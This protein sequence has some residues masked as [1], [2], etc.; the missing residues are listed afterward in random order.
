MKFPLLLEKDTFIKYI[1]FIPGNNQI[2]HHINAHL[3]TYESHQKEN[4]FNN[5]RYV[6]TEKFS[7]EESFKK[8]D[9]LQIAHNHKQVEKMMLISAQVAFPHRAS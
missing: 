3:I 2:V 8:L 9:I 7:D 6:N 4:I 5:P 1:E